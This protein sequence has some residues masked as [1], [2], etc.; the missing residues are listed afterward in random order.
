[1]KQLKCPKCGNIFQV[2]EADY[3]SIANQ[4]K[5]AEFD[6]ELTRRVEELHK[7]HEAEKTAA[8][9]VASQKQQEVASLHKE[10]SDNDG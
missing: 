4:V 6:A 8:D 10:Q 3:A 1:M 7:Q 5:N 9:A 2:D